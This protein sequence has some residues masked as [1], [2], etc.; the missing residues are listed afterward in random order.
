MA[1]RYWIVFLLIITLTMAAAPVFAVE[2]E[3]ASVRYVA[4][5][6]KLPSGEPANAKVQQASKNPLR[7]WSAGTFPTGGGDIL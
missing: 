2:P 5:T 4:A 3:G 7:L 1:I 6:K